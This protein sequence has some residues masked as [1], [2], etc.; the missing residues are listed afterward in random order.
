MKVDDSQKTNEQLI[1][2]LTELRRIIST[3]ASKAA[4]CDNLKNIEQHFRTLYEKAPIPYQSLDSDG[5]LIEINEAWLDVLGYTRNEVIGRWFGDFL[6]PPMQDL[7]RERFPCFKKA[8]EVHGYEFDMLRKDGTTIVVSFDGR[9]GYNDHGVFQQTHCVFADVTDR[10]QTENTQLFLSQYSWVRS[11]EDFFEALARHLAK[12]L[13]MDYVCVDRLVGDGLTA[14]TVAVYFDG[15]FEDN[16]QYTLKDTPCGDVVEQTICCFPKEVRHLFPRDV[17]LQEMRAESYV[18][19]TLWSSTGQPIGLI[20]VIGRRPLTSPKQ[21]ESILKLIAP[22]AAGELERRQVEQSLAENE[23][24]LRTLLKTIPDLVWLKDTGGVYLFCNPI[25]ER[26]YGAKEQDIIGKTDYD[27]VDKELADFFREHDRKAMTVGKPTANEEWLTFADNGYRGLFHTFKTP[28]HDAKG[29]LIGVLGIARDITE[30]NQAMELI[31][32]RIT[33]LTQP[34]AGG[35]ISFG[36]L[37]NLNEIQQIQ[38]EFAEATGVASI[39]TQPDGTPITA[40]S[41]FTNLCSEIIRKTEKGCSNC[42]KSD[43]AI[44]RYHPKD[45]IVQPCLSGGLWDA[46]ASITV[47]GHHIA[48][49]LIGQVRNETQNEE[50]MRAYAREIGADEESFIAKFLEVPSMP[51]ERFEKIARAL[52][53]LANQLSNTAYQNVQQARFITERKRAEEALRIAEKTFRDLLENIQLVAVLLD[54]EGNITFCNDYLLNLIGWRKDE[55]LG[56]NW[57]D[58]FIS[59]DEKDKLKR[60]WASIIEGEEDYLHYENIIVTREGKERL[61]SWNNTVLHDLAGKISGT[62]S[63]GIDITE[64]RSLEAQLRQAQKMEAVGQLAGGIAHDFNNI[65]SAIVGYAYLVQVRLG[66]DDPSR[67]DIDQILESAHK[68]AEVTHSLLA[69]S[70]KQSITLKPVLINAVVK[71]CEKMLSRII[72]ED[73]TINTMLSCNEATCMVDAAQIEQ[74]L[75]NLATN[76]RDAMPH[77]GTLALRTE[78]VAIDESFIRAHSYGKSGE[79][80]LISVSDTGSGM[81]EETKARIFEPFFTTKETG[82]GTGLGLAMVYGIIKQHEG[83]IN[84][85]SE[86]NVGTTFNAYLP[87]AESKEAI[88]VEAVKSPPIGGT[89]TILVTED[90]KQLRRLSEIILK[91]HGYKVILAQDG[92]EAIEQFVA[93]KERIN[94]ILLDMIMPKK[95]G[96][97]V[98]DEIKK[99][100]PGMKIIFVSGYTADRMDKENVAGEKVDFI[101][102]PISPNDLL[103]TVREVLDK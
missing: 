68:A 61:I 59:P 22:S 5:H 83:Y 69:F 26:L 79:Y 10:K 102:K 27:F 8:G 56:R 73:I 46:G 63:I 33:A 47:G 65:L 17:V 92:E 39:I 37:F 81:S 72:G 86:L 99:L 34:M 96:K 70:K 23:N 85:Y 90:N 71:R 32:K 6:P 74:V 44:G 40:Q 9:I 25:F 95:S 89:E 30:R 29:K 3:L 66:R 18:G 78:C 84:V 101:F 36:D 13:G 11:G 94:L 14:Q 53:T 67:D 100:N 28:V 62:A 50:S 87:T 31:E 45:P 93:N 1:Q 19:T 24:R 77:G 82:K 35:V 103:R 64:H 7:F 16:V 2:E 43:A 15:E 38:N 80:V 4:A 51:R 75:M 49:W 20:A 97:E 48:N 21:A 88:T 76:A 98:Y 52:F 55:I 60:A 42:F 12:N 41:N 57:F 54:H 91:Q 58:L